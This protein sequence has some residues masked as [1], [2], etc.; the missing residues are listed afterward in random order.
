ALDEYIKKNLQVPASCAS[1]E[2]IIIRVMIDEAGN[3]TKPKIL[4]KTGNCS[5][6]EKEAIRFV[7]AMPAW[8]AATADGKT[9]TSQKTLTLSFKK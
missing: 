5:D 9:F 1:E 6:C 8:I 4:S 3:V 2:I 7:K